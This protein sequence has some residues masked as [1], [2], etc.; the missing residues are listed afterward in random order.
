MRWLAIIYDNVICNLPRG[1]G[2]AYQ[3]VG[4]PKCEKNATN[5]TEEIMQEIMKRRMLQQ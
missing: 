4:F 1:N 3:W 2:T 5:F